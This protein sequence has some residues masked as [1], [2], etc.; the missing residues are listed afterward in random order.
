MSH[1]LVTGRLAALTLTQRTHLVWPIEAYNF[2]FLPCSLSR[3]HASRYSNTSLTNIKTAC[4]KH[5]SRPVESFCFH[6]ADGAAHLYLTMIK[7]LHTLVYTR[8]CAGQ[9]LCFYAV[10]FMQQE[11]RIGESPKMQHSSP[12]SIFKDSPFLLLHFQVE[13]FRL[14]T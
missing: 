4:Y 5:L 7:D 8:H 6:H 10:L 2:G 13:P 9:T 1:W 3:E 11:P 12:K 14:Q